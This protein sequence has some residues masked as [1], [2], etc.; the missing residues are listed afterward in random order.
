MYLCKHSHSKPHPRNSPIDTRWQRCRWP[1]LPFCLCRLHLNRHYR[2]GNRHRPHTRSCKSSEM[3]K[4]NLQCRRPQF[5]GHT[6]PHCRCLVEC[7]SFQL[8]VTA[9]WSVSCNLLARIRWQAMCTDHSLRRCS[10]QHNQCCCRRSYRVQCVDCPTPT[11]ILLSH[12]TRRSPRMRHRSSVHPGNRMCLGDMCSRTDS[13][14][15][16]FP[17]MHQLH[18]TFRCN[19]RL[20]R[21]CWLP[22]HRRGLPSRPGTGLDSRGPRS[23]VRHNHCRPL[24]QAEEGRAGSGDPVD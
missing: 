11:C 17:Y 19:A 24:V 6:R 20:G 3:H 16:V 4:R 23:T 5:Q 1:L 13:L 21:L 14:G 22:R 15:R 18:R 2:S 9:R 12:K 8:A 10:Y 7:S